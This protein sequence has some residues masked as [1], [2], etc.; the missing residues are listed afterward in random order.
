MWTFMDKE[1]KAS[2]LFKQKKIIKISACIYEIFQYNLNLVFQQ[3]N[4]L[5]KNLHPAFCA[6]YIITCQEHNVT[7]ERELCNHPAQAS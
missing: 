7:D 1:N 5:T 2:A 4:I 3:K 6:I